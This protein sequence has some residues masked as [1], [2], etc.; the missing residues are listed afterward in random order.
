M[1]KFSRSLIIILSIF[2]VACKKSD[3]KIKIK[4]EGFQLFD[5]LGN[6]ITRIGPPD[7][8]WQFMNWSSLSP[9]EQSLLNSVDNGNMS[10]TFISPVSLGPYPNPVI[11]RS[12]ITYRQT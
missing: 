11:D 8:D 12:A 2:C 3:D 7:N 5:A 1:N 4:I 9:F 10:N 6:S